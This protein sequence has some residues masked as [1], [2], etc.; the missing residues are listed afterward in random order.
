M[1]TPELR[2]K[3]LPGWSCVETHADDGSMPCGTMLDYRP[4][5]QLLRV[6]RRLV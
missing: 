1:T 5:E 3:K 4:A 6:R 2:L